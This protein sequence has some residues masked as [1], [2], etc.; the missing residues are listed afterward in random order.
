MGGSFNSFL[1]HTHFDL[2]LVS[3]LY[4]FIERLRRNID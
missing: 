4:T 2:S 1:Y 3:I